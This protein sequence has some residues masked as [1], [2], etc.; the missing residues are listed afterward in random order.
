MA[1]LTHSEADKAVEQAIGAPTSQAMQSFQ[2]F[3]SGNKG[4][5]QP[6]VPQ[7]PKESIKKLPLKVQ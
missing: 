6:T 3:M 1:L 2:R 7:L 4:L 5:P